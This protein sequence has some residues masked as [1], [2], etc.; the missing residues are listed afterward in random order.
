MEPVKVF[1]ADGVEFHDGKR[2]VAASP[3]KCRN[4][5]RVEPLKRQKNNRKE[6]QSIHGEKTVIYGETEAGKKPRQ[7]C[8]EG[9]RSCRK[10]SFPRVRF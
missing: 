7:K 2:R 9:P 3:Q 10:A 5:L 8:A 1:F 4:T 6:L